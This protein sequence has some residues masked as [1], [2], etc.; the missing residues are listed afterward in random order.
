MKD[1]VGRM[2]A[3][4][5]GSVPAIVGELMPCPFCPTGKG[6]IVYPSK[7]C[8]L[9]GAQVRCDTCDAAAGAAF[10]PQDE[11]PSKEV[12]DRAAVHNW[13]MRP[14][15]TDDVLART[16]LQAEQATGLGSEAKK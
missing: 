16:P 7:E 12:M 6:V 2:K 4:V 1:E 3:E 8:Y 10:W 9:A 13:N 14:A 15:I 5:E 11:A